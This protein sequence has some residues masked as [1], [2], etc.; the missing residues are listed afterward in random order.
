M[1]SIDVL[2]VDDHIAMRTVA[3]LQLAKLGIRAD[4]A[5][6]GMEAVRRVH[7][8]RYKLILMDIQMPDMNGLEAT[9]AIRSYE[10][11]E[12]LEPSI[13]VAVTGGGANKKQ[14]LAAG[15][16]GYVEK[17]LPA[18]ALKDLVREWAPA[19]LQQS[20]D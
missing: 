6:N 19:L 13:I 5:A 2:V 16:N 15:M 20:D 4:S 1:D 18:E 11:S 10:R 8:W 12:D 9:C 3:V 17:P 7:N 14:C